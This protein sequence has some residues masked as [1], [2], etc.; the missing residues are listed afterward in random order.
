MPA[1][2]HNMSLETA[3][4]LAELFILDACREHSI[5]ASTINLGTVLAIGGLGFNGMD[6]NDATRIVMDPYIQFVQGG[7]DKD[8]CDVLVEGVEWIS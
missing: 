5:D 6:F 3:N 4:C 8:F 2:D 1:S 7:I